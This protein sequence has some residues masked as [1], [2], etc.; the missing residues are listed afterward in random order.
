MSLIAARV[1]LTYRVARRYLTAGSLPVGKT[2]QNEK[3]RIHRYSDTL[4]V[5]D[6]TNAG[7]RGKK[8]DEMVVSPT[9]YY[10][11]DPDQWLARMGGFF[12]DEAGGGYKAISRFIKD[13]QTDFPTEIRIEVRPLQGTKVEPFGDVFEFDIPQPNKGSMRVRS[14]PLDFSVINRVWHEHPTDPT[15][16]GH[17][18]DTLCTPRKPVDAQAFYAWMK[19][20]HERARRLMNMDMF[21]QLWRAIRVNVDCH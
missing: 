12:V 2:F 17:F 15:K 4:V 8:C 3:V 14:T 7:K 16:G 6:L 20:N 21:R 5:T 1:A 13:V 19:D 11:G 10:E 18:Q 9:V